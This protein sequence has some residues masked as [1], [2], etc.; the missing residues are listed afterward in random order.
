[1]RVLDKTVSVFKEQ[2]IPERNKIREWPTSFFICFDSFSLCNAQY[3]SKSS[4]SLCP[5]FIFSF[6][7]YK[8]MDGPQENKIYWHKKGIKIEF[9]SLSSDESCESSNKSHIYAPGTKIEPP[10]SVE[11]VYNRFLHENEKDISIYTIKISSADS[12]WLVIKTFTQ[13]L[14]LLYMVNQNTKIL[15]KLNMKRFVSIKT[16]NFNDRNSLIVLIL[17]TILNDPACSKYIQQFILSDILKT[18]CELLYIMMHTPQDSQKICFIENKGWIRGW[19]PQ[20]LKKMNNL[21]AEV[22]KDKIKRIIPKNEIQ[23]IDKTVIIKESTKERNL[24]A[25]EKYT[26]DLLKTWLNE[27]EISIYK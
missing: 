26:I 18:Q 10:F 3:T 19:Q 13:I 23:I 12:S 25:L 6:F 17:S 8:C 9:D 16:T 2:I 5:F 1:M 20:M 15:E 11:V 27:D 14:E 21:I 7:F 4:I 22:S 24:V